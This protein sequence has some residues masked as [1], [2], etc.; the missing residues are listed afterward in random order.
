ME[1][2]PNS[3]A[4]APVTPKEEPEDS[5]IGDAAVEATARASNLRDQLQLQMPLCYQCEGPISPARA[6]HLRKEKM[7]T[8]KW[9]CIACH[10]VGVAKGQSG[11][12]PAT[13]ALAKEAPA[14][15]LKPNLQPLP[16]PSLLGLAWH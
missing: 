7:P 13:S 10:M 16:T 1:P 5:P 8:A 11:R 15:T 6:T 9:N 3:A 2:A 12:H 14:L 4:C